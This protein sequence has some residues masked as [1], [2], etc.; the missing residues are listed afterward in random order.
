MLDSIGPFVC[1]L[2]GY[3]VYI[4]I[5]PRDGKPFYVGKGKGERALAHLR[6]TTECRKVQRVKEI[7][8]AGQTPQIDILVH[9]LS[10]QEA[11]RIE[12]VVIDTIGIQNLT[13][14]VRGWETGKVGRMPLTELVAYTVQRKLR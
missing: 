4:Y 1:E 8:A 9:R 6:D 14:E 2:L 5:D 12:A 7:H 11:L 10:E 13:N 3:Y